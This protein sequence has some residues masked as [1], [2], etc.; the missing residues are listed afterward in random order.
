MDQ[1]G[2]ATALVFDLRE[3]SPFSFKCQVCSVCCSNKAIRVG[4]YEAL[5]LA[6][7]LRITT[8]ELLRTC[9]EE[10]GT[11]LLNNPD[12]SC[13]FL[14][15]RGCNVHP[16][17]PLVCRLFPLGLLEDEQGAVKFAIMPLHPDCLGLVDTDGTVE[18]YLES[19]GA[20]P[21]FRYEKLYSTLYKRIS[22]KLSPGRLLTLWADIDGA[23]AACGCRQGSGRYGDL[24]D[25][26]RLHVQAMKDRIVGL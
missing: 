12:G 4:P 10:G 24:D 1:A 23:L 6:R 14:G 5:R 15:S 2:L 25:L 8:T 20:T 22:A 26:V 17:R 11:I 3:H 18:T 13:V 19:Q 16:D 7:R 21:Y 9:T